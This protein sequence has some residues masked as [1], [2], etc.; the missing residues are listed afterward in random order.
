MPLSDIGMHLF[1]MMLDAGLSHPQ[2]RVEYLLDGGRDSIIYEWFAETLRTVLPK[3]EAS[4][5][6]SAAELDIDTLAQRM[7]DEAVA[8]GGCVTGPIFVSAAAR[9][10]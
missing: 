9:K 5:L 2:C 3:L 6:A 4:G 8:I 10:P 1:Q 7:R